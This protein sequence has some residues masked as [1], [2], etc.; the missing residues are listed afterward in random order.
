MIRVGALEK[1]DREMLNQAE[2]GRLRDTFGMRTLCIDQPSEPN[3]T[4]FDLHHS[5]KSRFLLEGDILAV[6][7]QLPNEIPHK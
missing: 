4:Q 2:K 6:C 3:A 5:A 1:H 7:E